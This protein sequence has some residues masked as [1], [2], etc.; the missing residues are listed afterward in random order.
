MLINNEIN[1]EHVKFISY[2]GKYPNLCSGTL[3]LMI[4][5]QYVFFGNGLAQRFWQSGGGISRLPGNVFGYQDEWII[6]AKKIPEKYRV[7]AEE[8][9]RVFN[10]NVPYG[11]CGGCI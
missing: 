9:D 2:S 11:C 8:I 7:Y 6:D 3:T 1:N 5:E 10:E 4:D